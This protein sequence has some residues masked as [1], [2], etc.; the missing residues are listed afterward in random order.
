MEF[1]SRLT[2]DSAL[3]ENV[4]TGEDSDQ[5]KGK[6]PLSVPSH[7]REMERHVLHQMTKELFKGLSSKNNKKKQWHK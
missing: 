2:S 3:F 7:T 5:S 4:V 1:A 6:T